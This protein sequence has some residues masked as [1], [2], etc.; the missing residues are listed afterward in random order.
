MTGKE[1]KWGVS[2]APESLDGKRIPVLMGKICSVLMRRL[3]QTVN[4]RNY[5]MKG[6]RYKTMGEVVFS[7]GHRSTVQPQGRPSSSERKGVTE[8]NNGNES[9][10]LGRWAREKKGTFGIKSHCG[11]KAAAGG[12]SPLH[13]LE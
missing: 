13:T 9:S 3:G 11:K 8:E 6:N 4:R 10:L 7:G 1:H 2:P 12:N 5:F